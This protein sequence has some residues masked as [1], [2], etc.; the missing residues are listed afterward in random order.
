MNLK[1]IKGIGPKSLELLEKLEI[2]NIEDLV[3]Y[4]PFRY[5][6]LKH[7]FIVIKQ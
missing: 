2:N 5:E 3:T 1:D 7:H 4:Y 6:Q